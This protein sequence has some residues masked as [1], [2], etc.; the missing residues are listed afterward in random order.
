[1]DVALNG[2]LV[3]CN[4]S[5]FVDH[6]LNICDELWGKIIRCFKSKNW[7]TN[8]V[9]H[10]CILCMC[11]FTYLFSRTLWCCNEMGWV[12]GAYG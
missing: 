6:R 7:P 2:A 1:M 12:C 4:Y 10:V 11:I 3:Y 8:T 9:N 5:P